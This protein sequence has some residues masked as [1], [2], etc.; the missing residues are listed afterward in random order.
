LTIS[1]IAPIIPLKN[2]AG[3]IDGT[4][5]VWMAENLEK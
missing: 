3:E 2:V 5:F 1:F 4:R